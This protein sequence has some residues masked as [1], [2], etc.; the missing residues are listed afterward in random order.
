MDD[1]RDWELVTLK[2]RSVSGRITLDW[3]FFSSVIPVVY[4]RNK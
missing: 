4:L 2:G 3:A 1:V